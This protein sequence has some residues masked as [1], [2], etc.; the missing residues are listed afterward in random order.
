MIIKLDCLMSVD[1]SEIKK[2]DTMLT[3]ASIPHDLH[4]FHEGWQIT[5]CYDGEWELRRKGCGDVVIHDGSYGHESG[6]LEAMGFD[7]TDEEYGDEVVGYLKAE[8]AFE[9][10]KRQYEKDKRERGIK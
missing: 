6:L 10:F 2:L 8:R 5:Y 3:R 9:F 4:K 7:I 1:D